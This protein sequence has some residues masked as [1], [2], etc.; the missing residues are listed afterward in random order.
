[1]TRPVVA[2]WQGRQAR[3]ENL[4]ATTWTDILPYSVTPLT[5]AWLDGWYDEIEPRYAFNKNK[6]PVSNYLGILGGVCPECWSFHAMIDMPDGTLRC[7]CFPCRE[8][9]YPPV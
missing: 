5:W 9:N 3:R 6:E 7:R 4:H 8:R 1:M 2:Y